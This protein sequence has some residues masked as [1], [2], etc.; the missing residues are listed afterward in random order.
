MRRI[1]LFIDKEETRDRDIFRPSD[2]SQ[3]M[4]KEL[5][6]KGFNSGNKVWLSAVEQYLTSD[7]VDYKYLS[8]DMDSV[9]INSS[10]DLV[11][12]P[13]ANRIRNDNDS[14]QDLTEWANFFD[15]LVIPV[16]ILGIGAQAKNF[17]ELDSFSKE[18]KP[19]LQP[20]CSAIKKTGGQIAVR[21]EFTNNVLKKCGYQDAITIGCPSLYRNGPDF[22]I[23]KKPFTS[24]KPLLNI[25]INDFFQRNIQKE[26]MSNPEC[27]AIDQNSF[28]DLLFDKSSLEKICMK[29]HLKFDEEI[30]KYSYPAL[31]LLSNNRMHFFYDEPIWKDYLTRNNFTF[32]YGSRIHGTIMAILSGVPA[33]L[34]NCDSRTKE[35]AEFFH[36][37]VLEDKKA[38]LVELYQMTDYTSFNENYPKK[39]EAFKNLLFKY[40]INISETNIINYRKKTAN[41]DYLYPPSIDPGLASTL[42]NKLFKHKGKLFTTN[43]YKRLYKILKFFRGSKR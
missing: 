8:K 19:Y 40:G 25:Q 1:L 39:Y 28:Y 11:V 38:S 18:M 3:D 33:A 37:P 31:W 4:L 20:F 12:F 24:F 34:F 30:T 21:G 14:K 23:D 13:C 42:N 6:F 22:R 29:K 10:F 26:I 36:I 5:H 32:A 7:S 2:Y 41:I 9:F 15:Q 43:L 35:I 27:E 16:L 17:E